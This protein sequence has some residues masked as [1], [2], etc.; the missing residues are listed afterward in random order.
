MGRCMGTDVSSRHLCLQIDPAE[1]NLTLTPSMSRSN[2][3]RCTTRLEKVAAVPTQ[4]ASKWESYVDK[5]TGEMR[6]VV[7][8]MW[9]GVSTVSCTSCTPL[10]L[11]GVMRK[12]DIPVGHGRGL[13]LWR[14]IS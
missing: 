11:D 1:R 2:L 5:H 13:P 10:A 6:L 8:N 14:E 7:A 3:G 4:G 9:D 12:R